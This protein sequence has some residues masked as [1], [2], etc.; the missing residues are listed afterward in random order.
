MD[1]KLKYEREKAQL[2]QEAITER[3]KCSKT[4]EKQLEDAERRL[5]STLEEHERVAEER[6]MQN[7]EVNY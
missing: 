1:L 2:V 3:D 5:R 4:Y 7:Q 6:K